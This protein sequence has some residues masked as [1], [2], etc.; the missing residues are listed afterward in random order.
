MSDGE[1]LVSEGTSTA[2]GLFFGWRAEGGFYVRKGAYGSE[3][4]ISALEA[5]AIRRIIG[6]HQAEQFKVEGIE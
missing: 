4:R 6:D 5:A 3:M 1:R 2:S